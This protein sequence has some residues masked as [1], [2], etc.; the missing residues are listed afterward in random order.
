MAVRVPIE[1]EHTLE[2]HGAY[3]H[4]APAVDNLRAEAARVAAEMD[5][6]RV[7]MVNS[8]REGGGVAEMLPTVVGLLR[9]LGLDARWVV[10]ESDEPAFFQLTKNVH[11]LIHGAGDPD[12]LTGEAR[13]LYESENRRNA[14]FLVDRVEPGD[15]LVVHD[16][17]PMP[18]AR[19]VR[20]EVEVRTM[21]R[22]HIGLDD[23]NASTRAAWE[24]LAPYTEDY[25]RAIFSAPEYIPDC[26]AGRA[27]LIRPA[28]DPLTDK[29]RALS[30][31]E[32][33]RTLSHAA[34][35]GSPGPLLDPPF[36]DVV[37]RLRADGTFVPASLTEDIGLLHR[38][39]V[40]QISRW[41]RL[42]GF[43]PLMEAFV[44][45]KEEQR[46]FAD[47][48]SPKH[49]RRLSLAR[50]VL[51]GPEA[52]AVT[53]DPEARDVL[54]EMRQAYRELSP[55]VQ[56]DVAVLS[57][58][59][60]VRTEN[61]RIVNAV[62]RTSS[63][64]C[65]NS[66]REGFGLTITEAMWKRVPVL[67]NRRACGPRQQI[68]DRLHGRLVEDPEDVEGVA[69]ALDAMLA[70][71]EERA[72]WGRA[73]QRRVHDEFLIYQQLRRYVEEFAQLVGRVRPPV[74]AGRP[75]S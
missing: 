22:C 1:R 59:M 25:E 6:R 23:E 48:R 65:Q 39:V 24:F 30:V 29:N 47:G 54:D 38:P 42:K 13:T 67:S 72:A 56:N 19:F 73:A 3:A 34:L 18:L 55:M 43:G 60:S 12:R 11:N 50:L 52:G 71:P 49:R 51:A 2:D 5:D 58:P 53:D 33:V 27:T 64:V 37:D 26:L 16:P 7:W 17:Q 68:V 61:H 44:R 9:D 28:I 70:A 74:P 21:W 15:V 40:T 45:L 32:V 14:Q 63:I 75:A 20:E 31:H 57:L 69:S 4:L 62:Q 8:A 36:E 66:L 35:D 10:I 46:A 41:D